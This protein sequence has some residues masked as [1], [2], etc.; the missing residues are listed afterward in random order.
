MWLV[1]LCVSDML[2]WLLFGVYFIVL[3]SRLLNIMCSVLMFVM[4]FVVCVFLKLRLML[5]CCVS[6]VCVVMYLVSSVCRLIGLCIV[7]LFGLVCVSVSSCLVR[8]VVCDM[9]FWRFVIVLWCDVLFFVCV[10]SCVWICMVVS[11]VCNL[12]VVLVMNVFCVLS[13][14]DSCVSSLFSVCM[15][16]CILSGRCVLG[17]GLSVFGWCVLIV[18]VM[19][20]S[21]VSLCLMIFYVV[22]LRNGSSMISGYSVCSVMFVVSWLCIDSGCVSCM[23]LLLMIVLYMCYLL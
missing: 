3:L 1:V 18:C 22:V 4:M 20:L 23:M 15:S 13:V 8:C 5:C 11:G 19:W 12:C 17:S 7:V 2:M 10:M 6:G 14:V 21:G 9:L 16:G